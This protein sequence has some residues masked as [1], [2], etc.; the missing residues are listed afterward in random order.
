MVNFKLGK[1]IRKEVFFRLVSRAGQGKNSKVSNLAVS[2]LKV[3]VESLFLSGRERKL[4]I[5]RHQTR[6]LFSHARNEKKKNL[7]L[8]LLLL[9]ICLSSLSWPKT[10]AFFLTN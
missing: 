6:F 5:G 7:S 8:L 9:N 3:H 1:E 4:G 2:V 10:K